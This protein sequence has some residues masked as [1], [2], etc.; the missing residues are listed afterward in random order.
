MH[1]V[2]FDQ[3]AADGS[4]TRVGD[5]EVPVAG[6]G[7]V[8]IDVRAAGVNFID[9][10]ARR[11]DPGYATGWPFVPGL[12]AAGTIRALG[13]GVDGLAVGMPVVA[14]TTAGGLAEVVKVPAGLVSPIPAGLTFETAAAVPGTLTTA[15]LLLR[16]LR[17]GGS[18]LVHSAGGGLGQALAR[19]A[20]RQEAGLILGTV[21]HSS[22]SAGAERAGYDAVLVRDDG[23][24][25]AVLRRTDGRGVDLILD[26]QGTKWIDKDLELVAPTGR[27]MLYGNASGAA[28]DAIPT[29]RLF[30]TN[31]MV[32]AFSM[33]GLAARAPWLIAEAQ[34]EALDAVARG[35]LPV[36]VTPLEGLQQVA[37]AQQAL[38]DGRGEGKY[39][40]TLPS[41]AD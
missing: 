27:I 20:R 10:M 38:A 34:S 24:S 11:G 39:V 8:T 22:R 29:G 19:V 37:G 9:V 18:V 35:E 12:E 21:G 5:V 31:A 26:S 23:L 32:G 1:A 30:A 40:V 2:I 33:R 16:S 14:F 3:P 13:P 17:P 6:P 41:R 4:A 25:A 7:E 36:E 15:V 28:L